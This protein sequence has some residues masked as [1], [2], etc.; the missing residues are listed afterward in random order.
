[1]IVPPQAYIL[2]KGVLHD[3]DSYSMFVGTSLSQWL[4]RLEVDTLAVCGI[5]TEYCVL[6]SVRDAIRN[7][8]KVFLLEDLVRPIDRQPGDADKAIAE[9]LR[10]GAKLSNSREWMGMLERR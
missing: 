10:L 4:G 7:R 6:E 2:D 1:M 3:D 9:M 5:A 8:L